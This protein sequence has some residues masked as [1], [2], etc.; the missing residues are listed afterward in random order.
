MR[1]LIFGLAC[2]VFAMNV[3]AEGPGKN[4]ELEK[5]YIETRSQLSDNERVR[6]QVLGTLYSINKKMKVMSQKRGALTDKMFAARSDTQ[7]KARGIAELETKVEIQRK[8][9]SQRLRVLYRMNVQSALRLLFS[10]STPI[11]LDRNLKYLRLIT[12]HDYQLIK[13]FEANLNVLKDQR[14][15]LKRHVRR[16]AKI[17]QEL[18]GQEGLLAGEQRSKAVLLEKLKVNQDQTMARYKSIKAQDA[19]LFET[20]FF[21]RKGQLISPI[22]G[23]IAQEYGFIQDSEFRYRL[24]H[25]GLF[26]KVPRGTPVRSVHRGQV[27]YVGQVYGN[28][29]T[30]ILDHGDHYHTVY[31]AMSN[32][33]V[34]VGDTVVEG[35]ALAVSDFSEF[36]GSPG[37]YFEI[38]HF[39]DAIDPAAWIKDNHSKR[40]SQASYN[41]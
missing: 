14:E 19:D 20:A 5:S 15:I 24:S 22:E 29:W 36:H 3:V 4:E 21:E 35:Q 31:T 13:D 32:V 30:I 26:Y 38:R 8:Q 27:A 16:L 1:G 17:Q 37:M 12:D 7:N 33:T 25:K 2:L 28:G 23:P 34:K 11:E 6:R 39:S 9:L 40:V 18:K 10:A 41:Y